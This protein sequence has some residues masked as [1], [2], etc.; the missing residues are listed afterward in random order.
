MEQSD[1]EQSIVLLARMKE[2][3]WD[4]GEVEERRDGDGVEVV[5]SLAV[6]ERV[7]I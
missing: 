4:D 5:R 6:I 2:I 1:G 7:E 3:G